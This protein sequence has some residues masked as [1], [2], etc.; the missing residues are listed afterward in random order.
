MWALEL[1][2]IAAVILAGWFVLSVLWNAG[3]SLAAWLVRHRSQ[4]AL[5][6]ATAR[7]LV[8]YR[9]LPEAQCAARDLIALDALDEQE[10][11]R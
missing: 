5:G 10:A 9:S 7:L 1:A 6:Y 11:A 2:V 3:R 8:R 4:R